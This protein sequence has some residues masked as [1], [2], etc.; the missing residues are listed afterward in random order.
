[1][2]LKDVDNKSFINNCILNNLSIKKEPKD[3]Q[4]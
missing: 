3:I 1:M 2:K 4:M